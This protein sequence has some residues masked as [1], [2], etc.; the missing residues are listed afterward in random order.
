M[1]DNGDFYMH[2]ISRNYNVVYLHR[3]LLDGSKQMGTYSS[4]LQ[5]D[6]NKL[7]SQMIQDLQRAPAQLKE[8]ADSTF[9]VTVLFGK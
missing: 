1:S 8:K 6:N 5:I 9:M 4:I 7:S 2:Y 3:N